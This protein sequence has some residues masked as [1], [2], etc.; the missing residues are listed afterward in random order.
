MI[1]YFVEY[2]NFSTLHTSFALSEIIPQ[3]KR[4]LQSIAKG[5]GNQSFLD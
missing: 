5:G 2:L 4:K 3:L 1:P